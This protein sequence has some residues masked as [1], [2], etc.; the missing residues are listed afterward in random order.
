M[1]PFLVFQLLVL[2]LLA[3]GTP[4]VATKLGGNRLS[5]PIDGGIKFFDGQPVFGPSKTF[6]GIISS[7]LVTTLCAPI[8]GLEWTVGAIVGIAAMA[9]DLF[10]SFLKRRLR[11]PP[12]SE[13]LG[14]DQ[15]PESLFPLISC[16]SILALTPLDIAVGVGTFY[17]AEQ[18]LSKIFHR[19]RLT[20]HHARK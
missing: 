12:S 2:L 3:N 9:G 15:V 6:R 1:Q 4:I 10:S 17:I 5:Y 8:V 13:A 20:S 16:R 19:L 14:L 7:L 11:F 18:I